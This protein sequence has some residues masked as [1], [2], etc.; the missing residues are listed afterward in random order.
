MGNSGS[1]RAWSTRMARLSQRAS[2]TMCTK[3]L[4]DLHTLNAGSMTWL[5]RMC[6]EGNLKGSWNLRERWTRANDAGSKAM[7]CGV[8]RLSGASRHSRQSSRTGGT[9]RS[10]RWLTAR[11]SERKRKPKD[12]PRVPHVLSWK[13][14]SFDEAI[15][16]SGDQKALSSALR[17]HRGC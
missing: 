15:G 11:S 13:P 6:A 10:S 2:R 12:R 1:K 3:L 8:E 16:F 14:W 7:A 4:G 5:D 17:S 9:K